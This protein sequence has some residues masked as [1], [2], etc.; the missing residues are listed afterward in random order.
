MC[1]FWTPVCAMTMAA[2]THAS[3]GVGGSVDELEGDEFETTLLEATDDVADE[4]SL[5]AVG[6]RWDEMTDTGR[7]VVSRSVSDGGQGG[8]TLTMIYVRSLMLGDM[9]EG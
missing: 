1:E 7:L 2:W 3:R 9:I 6:L 4:T 8:Q 5:D